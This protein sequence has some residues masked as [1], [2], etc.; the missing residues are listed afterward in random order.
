MADAL[1][2]HRL[3]RNPCEGVKAPKRTHKRREYLDHLQVEQLA[4]AVGRDGFIVR[5]KAYTGLRWGELADLTVGAVDLKR[6]RLQ[7]N[8][9]YSEA[10]GQ[11]VWKAPKDHERRSVPSLRSSRTNF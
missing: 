2:D 9:S 4:A 1:S 8:G 10:G 11:V 6:R 5:F 7:I 3:V